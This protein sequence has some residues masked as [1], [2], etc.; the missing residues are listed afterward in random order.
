M[1]KEHN[2]PF[3]QVP[4]TAMPTVFGDLIQP[5]LYYDVSTLM[6][7]FATE[8]YRAASKLSAIGLKPGVMWGNKAVV[9]LAFY[10]YRD[11]SLGPYNEV[12]LAIPALPAHQSLPFGGWLDL[13]ASVKTRRL[14]FYILN[15]PV[16]SEFACQSGVEFYGYPKFVT[17]IPFHLDSESFNSQVRDPN[18]KDEI[19]TLSGRLGPGIPGRAMDLVTFSVLNAKSMRAT[20]NVRGGVRMRTG[21]G[22]RLQV[23]LSLH[24]M[25]RNCCDL[26]LDGA[27]PFLVSETHEFQS[28]LNPAEEYDWT[29]R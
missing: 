6:A 5:A 1:S 20:V 3:F 18:G 10:E 27:R 22:L 25:A 14:G 26:G 12:G 29:A 17:E 4:T 13:Y 8:Y 23:G 9:G 15:L 2:S 16:T 28:R 11:T 21:R 24:E 19:V 7:F